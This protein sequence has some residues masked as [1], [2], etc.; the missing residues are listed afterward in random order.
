[1]QLT[2][3]FG[4]NFDDFLESILQKKKRNKKEKALELQRPNSINVS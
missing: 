1:M 2:F 4:F 3:P